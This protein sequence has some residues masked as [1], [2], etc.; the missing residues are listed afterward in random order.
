MNANTLLDNFYNEIAEMVCDEIC[1]DN[2]QHNNKCHFDTAMKCKDK[3]DINEMF[4]SML[5]NVSKTL[6]DKTTDS[7]DMPYS[8]YYIN[9]S[10]IDWNKE[11]DRIKSALV[12]SVKGCKGDDGSKAKLVGKAKKLLM[13]RV[14]PFRVA[15][16]FYYKP[17]HR[18]YAQTLYEPFSKMLSDMVDK[19]KLPFTKTA[20]KSVQKRTKEIVGIALRNAYNNIYEKPYIPANRKPSITKF[21]QNITASS[22]VLVCVTS[23][24][25]V[26]NAKN[27]S[28]MQYEKAVQD[29]AEESQFMTWEESYEEFAAKYPNT[30]TLNT[31]L[32]FVKTHLP[33]LYGTDK[34]TIKAL[35]NRKIANGKYVIKTSSDEFADYVNYCYGIFKRRGKRFAYES[36]FE[37]I[38]SLEDLAAIHYL[39]VEYNVILESRLPEDE[40][41]KLSADI[42]KNNKKAFVEINIILDS[43]ASAAVKLERM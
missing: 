42:K 22:P 32:T 23:S 24:K 28:E 13:T 2:C 10:V 35:L 38:Q 39:L 40:F 9:V 6:C 25:T 12:K 20:M 34:N 14:S 30:M 8:E 21:E 17:F 3:S 26:M 37:L 16:I 18:E 7:S 4:F 29:S 1:C 43:G 15:G 31:Y 5:D 41:K 33:V 19:D 11:I 36:R 27:K